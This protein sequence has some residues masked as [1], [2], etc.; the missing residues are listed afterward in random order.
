MES[1]GIEKRDGMEVVEQK[2]KRPGNG[3][4]QRLSLGTETEPPVIILASFLDPNLCTQL[5]CL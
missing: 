5:F 3:G 1:E 4:P 2:V